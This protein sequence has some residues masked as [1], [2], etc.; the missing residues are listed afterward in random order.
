MAS[1][2]AF[3]YAMCLVRLSSLF[4]L[5]TVVVNIM[6]LQII[7]QCEALQ[8][9]VKLVRYSFKEFIYFL[10]SIKFVLTNYLELLL[11]ISHEQSD[12][13]VFITTVKRL[14]CSNYKV[15]V[16]MNLV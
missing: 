14:P 1:V 13:Y 11:Y 12:L 6:Y 10:W 4:P 15:K 9:A 2:M 8:N 3:N 7:Y 5:I 16:S